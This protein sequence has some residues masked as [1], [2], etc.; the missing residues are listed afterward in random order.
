M[1]T[2][3]VHLETLLVGLVFALLAVR[4]IGSIRRRARFAER[5]VR[6]P[7]TI[8]I[9]DP[10]NIDHFIVR[11][12]HFRTR[13]LTHALAGSLDRALAAGRAPEADDLLATRA[14]QLV[15]PA[16]CEELAEVWRH[17]ADPS[18]SRRQ[19]RSLCVPVCRDRVAAA[20]AEIQQLL[21]V[22]ATPGP[23]AVR[24][25]AMMGELLSNG[26]G[27]LFNDHNAT[28]LSA[29]I[30]RATQQLDPSGVLSD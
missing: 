12:R 19:G 26:A 24:G 21:E 17:I 28:N 30:Q 4:W 2:M 8:I 27:P 7:S 14:Q 9:M 29:A 5:A 18:R 25:V 11:D 10:N 23:K 16:R 20:A 1:A 15:S 6:A 22:L 3:A 13:I